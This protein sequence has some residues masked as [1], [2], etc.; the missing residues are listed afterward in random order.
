ML[1]KKQ[2]GNFCKAIKKEKSEIIIIVKKLL[3][4]LMHDGEFITADRYGFT[5]TKTVPYFGVHGT[6]LKRKI[7]MRIPKEVYYGEVGMFR[8]KRIILKK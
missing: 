6:K 3:G 8:G 5:E 4:V 2:F 1:T 7:I